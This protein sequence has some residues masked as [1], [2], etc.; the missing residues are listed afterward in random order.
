M[1]SS[2][3]LP[4]DHFDRLYAADHDPWG[5]E[6][7]W[8]EDRKRACVTAALPDPHFRSVF[9]PGCANGALSVLLAPR[10]DRLLCWEP[11]VRPAEL[12]AARV[13]VWRHARVEQAAVPASWPGEMFDLIVVSELAYYL[14]R[15]DRDALW[16]AAIA[17]LDPGGTL[18]AI[19]W[20]RPAPE[21]PTTG[22]QVHDELVRR[23]GLCVVATHVEADFRLDV[24]GRTPPRTRSV[25]EC[26]GLR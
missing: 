14:D 9:E 18:L 23:D 16:T 15:A 24:L 12:A 25:A 7:G 11:V 17:S 19:H 26:T 4:G 22:D 2:R 8:Y 13:A 1:N 20:T 21:H 10:C 6:D 3:S 5:L